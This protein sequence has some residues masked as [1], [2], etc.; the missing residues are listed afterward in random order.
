MRRYTNWGLVFVGGLLAVA[1][2]I[3]PIWIPLVQPYLVDEVELSDFVCPE[4]VSNAQCNVLQEMY[5]EDPETAMRLSDLINPDNDFEVSDPPPSQ[6]ADE[7][8]DSVRSSDPPVPTIVKSGVFSTPIDAIHNATGEIKFYQIVTAD[9]TSVLNLV[10]LESAREEGFTVTYVPDLTLY[11]SQHPN[12]TTR[13]ELFSGEGGAYEVGQLKGNRGRQNY[14]I[15][16][17]IDITRYVSAVIYSP[18]LDQVFGVAF[19]N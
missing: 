10:R 4:F 14:E 8:Q 12:P 11:L 5:L 18:S 7:L 6:L 19:I 17:D 1:A 9:N 16:L 2:L 13:E 3:S 15:G